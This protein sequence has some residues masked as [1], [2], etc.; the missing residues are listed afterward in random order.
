VKTLL[1]SI[2]AGLGVAAAEDFDSRA[3]PHAPADRHAAI[4]FAPRGGGVAA[5]EALA[6]RHGLR[7]AR[8]NRLGIADA[9]ARPGR[10]QAAARRLALDPG[11]RWAEVVAPG[12]WLIFGADPP[13]PDD[14]RFADAWHLENTGQEGGL[15]GADL[16]ARDAWR[17][18]TG[19]GD[20]VVALLDSGIEL[21]HTD[22]WGAAWRNPG[23]SLNG[24][25]DD[26]NGFI[27]DLWGWDFANDNNDPRPTDSSHGTR[28][29]GVIAARTANGKGVAGIAGGWGGAGGVRV[30][31][32]QI[33]EAGPYSE[34]LDDAVLYAIDAG[35]QIISL[36]LSVSP[37]QAIDAALAEARRAGVLLV[38]AS[39]NTGHNVAYPATLDDAVAIS[40]TTRGDTLWSSSARGPEIRLAAPAKDVWTT[41]IY[42]RY[43]SAS[44]TS[45][46][47]PLAAGCAALVASASPFAPHRDAL[48]LSLALGAVDLGAAGRDDHYGWGRIDAR[49]AIGV[50]NEL[51]G[52]VQGRVLLPRSDAALA[53]GARVRAAAIAF[54][55]LVDEAEGDYLLPLPEGAEQ[56]VIAGA[57]GLAPDSAWVAVDAGGITTLDL[58]PRALAGGSVMGTCTTEEGV[59]TGAALR[60]LP[61]QAHAPSKVDG[62]FQ[63]DDL[64]GDSLVVLEARAVL[65]AAPPESLV[66]VAGDTLATELVLA[67]VQDFDQTS[68]GMTARGGVWAH[69]VG[70]DA[71]SAPALWGA[72]L[73]GGYP[74]Q[75]DASLIAPPL[76]VRGADARIAFHHQLAT[77]EGYDGGNL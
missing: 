4:S 72:P 28:V 30:M 25:D 43:T 39:G 46:A 67:P 49:A 56:L 35:A 48:L 11:V 51:L 61:A 75:A 21:E 2:A 60:V 42:G 74:N 68:G 27:D 32:L 37:S 54:D 20:I 77:E 38:A 12:R 59:A 1:L 31:A 22:L 24:L 70:P 29:A 3:L 9:H 45:F 64:P 19:E 41:D 7:L 36:S 33:G 10:A 69:G 8:V 52:H 26:E 34:V 63:L 57:W 71:H 47:A 44:G 53:R 15:P 66:I 73:G 58:A 40:G 76:V 55:V 50:R 14:P 62:L 6:R 16:A 18:S 17:I 5:A 65:R 13:L 23:E